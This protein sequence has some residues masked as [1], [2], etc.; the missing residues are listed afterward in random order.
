[1]RATAA[2]SSEAAAVGAFGQNAG[3]PA[4]TSAAGEDEAA[5]VPLHPSGRFLRPP[6]V[7]LMKQFFASSLGRLRLVGFLEGL[8]FLV[9]LGIAMPLKYFFGQPTAVRAV[10][11]AHGAL[12]VLYCLLVIGA[13]VRYSWSW[14]KTTL[15]F[16]ASIIPFGTFWA[17]MKLFRDD[18]PAGEAR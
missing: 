14:R 2:V 18:E 1:M 6:F 10:G 5:G 11:T 4:K 17:D 7:V 16:V 9:L 8:S 15:A 12:F 3:E 13:A